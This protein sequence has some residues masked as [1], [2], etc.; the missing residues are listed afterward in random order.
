MIETRPARASQ[1]GLKAALLSDR[2]NKPTSPRRFFSRTK[3]MG[4]RLLRN[5]PE[6]VRLS[7]GVSAYEAK[8]LAREKARERPYLGEYI[9]TLDVGELGPIRYER[10]HEGRGPLHSMGRS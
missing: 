6:S 7:S 4:R 2:E 1:E 3:A 8:N 10:T 9:A 5:D